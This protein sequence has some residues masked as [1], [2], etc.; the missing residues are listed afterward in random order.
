MAHARQKFIHLGM[1]HSR[2][3]NAVLI[4]FETAGRRFAVIGGEAIH[5]K[6]PEGFWHVHVARMETLFRQDRFA[7]GINAFVSEIGS[8]LAETFPRCASDVNEFPDK[9]SW[10]F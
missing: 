8:L 5:A 10:S 6:V 3:K 1:G 9:I 7:D 4:F 2:E